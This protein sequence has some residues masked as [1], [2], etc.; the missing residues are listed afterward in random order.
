MSSEIESLQINRDGEYSLPDYLH[1]EETADQHE[2]LTLGG[3]ATRSF[4]R[5]V[6]G[7]SSRPVKPRKQ[8]RTVK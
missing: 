2:A 4:V 8:A 1:P 5:T 6:L 7:A 3:A